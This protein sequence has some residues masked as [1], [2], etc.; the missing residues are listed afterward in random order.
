MVRDGWSWARGFRLDFRE[1]FIPEVL[2]LPREWEQPQSSRSLD[3]APRGAQGGI[4]GGLE[5]H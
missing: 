4:V 1:R 5:L 2:A 3:R